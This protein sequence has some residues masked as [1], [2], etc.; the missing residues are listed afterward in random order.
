MVKGGKA[1]SLKSSRIAGIKICNPNF[2]KKIV[3]LDDS[4]SSRQQSCSGISLKDGWYLQSTA[5]KNQQVNLE[6]SAISS[7]HNY[8]RLPSKQVECQSRLGVQECNRLIR[9]ETSSESLSENNQTFRITGSR[10]I[11]LQAVSPTSPIYGMEARSKQFCSGCNQQDWNKMFGFAFPPFSLIGQVINK[12]LRENVEAMILVTPTWQTQLWYTLL[13]RMSIQRPLHFT[14][15]PK[16]ITKSHGRKTSFCENQVNKFSGMENYRKNLEIEG[17][18]SSE[19]KRISLSRRPGS[20]AG[21]E[22]AWNKWASWW[23]RQQIDPVC[24]PLSGILNYLSTLFEKGLQYRTINSHCSAILAYHNYADEKSV[25]KHPRACALL[26]GV[27]NQRLPQPR[28]TFVWD[29]ETVLVYLKTN[30][31]DQLF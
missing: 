19:A 27:F 28:H 26:T 23:C 7:D 10:Y 17:I 30:M 31:S 14:S 3:V 21:C 22:S 16:P 15:P 8:C 9:L 25:G 13:L 2:P 12:V 11:C 6:L 24:A 29:V 4:C 18:S 20:F 5:S 1:F